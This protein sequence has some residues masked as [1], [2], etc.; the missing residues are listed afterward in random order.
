M[1]GHVTVYGY[2]A[3]LNLPGSQNS[4]Q[5]KAMPSSS[6]MKLTPWPVVRVGR[7]LPYGRLPTK[8]D[9]FRTKMGRQR[10]FILS[11]RADALKTYISIS[12]PSLTKS[13]FS[14]SKATGHL[15]DWS[16]TQLLTRTDTGTESQ[17]FLIYTFSTGQP[18]L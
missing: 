4:R 10:G 3:T 18:G 7:S 17:V 8:A 15:S 1:S 2:S 12:Q 11:G 6:T 13:T 5:P 9:T 16:T 14:E